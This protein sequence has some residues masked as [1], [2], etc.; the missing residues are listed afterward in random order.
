MLG[1]YLC[2]AS[3]L[4]ARKQ[5]MRALAT[6]PHTPWTTT[7]PL[8]HQLHFLAREAPQQERDIS[9]R[10]LLMTPLGFHHTSSHWGERVI[11]WFLWQREIQP[12]HH[13]QTGNCFPAMHLPKAY[14]VS[15]MA[16]CIQSPIV[17]Q[18]Q[19]V[20]VLNTNLCFL[21]DRFDPF[22]AVFSFLL[23]PYLSCSL[24]PG[25]QRRRDPQQAFQTLGSGIP[26]DSSHKGS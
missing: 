12:C 15:F 1:Q 14:I 7:M 9:C 18:S 26:C 17:S 6:R 11:V 22:M 23:F 24:R 5:E 20:R 2:L 10:K 13:S 21:S 19:L 8:K 25:W 16:I 4:E 3:P